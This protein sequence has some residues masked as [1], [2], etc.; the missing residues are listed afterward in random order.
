MRAVL[1]EGA[2]RGDLQSH[3]TDVVP[4]QPG[5]FIQIVERKDTSNTQAD[6][7]EACF[8]PGGVAILASIQLEPRR[9][10]GS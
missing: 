4:G 10:L 8:G 5:C 7:E 2:A 1:D 3:V 9:V 6:G